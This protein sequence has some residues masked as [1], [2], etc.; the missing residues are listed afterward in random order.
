MPVLRIILLFCVLGMWG[1]IAVQAEDEFFSGSEI[2]AG[3]RSEYLYNGRRMAKNVMETQLSFGMALNNYCDFNFSGAAYQST[4]D[5]FGNVNGYGEFIF[6]LS[7]GF[8]LRPFGSANAYN[9]SEFK[10][11]VELGVAIEQELG[12]EWSWE[13]KGLY[14]TGQSG[15][16][17]SFRV[18]YFPLISGDVGLRITVGTGAGYDYFESRGINEWFGRI[19]LPIKVGSSSWV[20][21]P[22]MGI[23]DQHSQKNAET[24][25]YA[26][27]WVSF[28]Y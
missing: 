5:S 26:G 15:S 14:D 16:Y 4:C 12:K 22:F 25:L 7:H 6:Y 9:E 8:N 17:G 24:R 11:G 1:G 27:A 2:R 10:S 19:S 20:I 21:E 28:L 3:Y 18:N 13:I 23:S